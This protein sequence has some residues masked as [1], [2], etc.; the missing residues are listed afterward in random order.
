MNMLGLERI[1]KGHD[2]R[3]ME[4]RWHQL[5]FTEGRRGAVCAL[6]LEGRSR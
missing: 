6:A 1:E 3:M 4:R 2:I 5:L